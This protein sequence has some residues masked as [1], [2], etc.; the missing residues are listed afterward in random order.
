MKN[1]LD[2]IF[3]S[4]ILKRDLRVSKEES[5]QKSKVIES[6][7]QDLKLLAQ[8]VVA[9][10]DLIKSLRNQIRLQTIENNLLKK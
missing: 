5:D 3:P 6:Q 10:A 1:I 7:K 2:T 4:R 9:A 8:E